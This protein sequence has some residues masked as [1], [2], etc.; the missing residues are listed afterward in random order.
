MFKFLKELFKPSTYQSELER[1]IV[2]HNPQSTYDVEK[3]T[4]EFDKK[5]IKGVLQ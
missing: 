4:Q 1:Y 5:Q 3:L 2:A